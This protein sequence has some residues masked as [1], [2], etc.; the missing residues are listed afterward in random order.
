MRQALRVN[1]LAGHPQKVGNT[2]E[3][4]LSL[5][6]KQRGPDKANIRWG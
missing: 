1:Q 3:K 4:P 6:V 2:L 5:L